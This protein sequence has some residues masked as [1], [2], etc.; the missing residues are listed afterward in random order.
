MG[1]QNIL[2]RIFE[3]R[4]EWKWKYDSGGGFCAWCMVENVKKHH[5]MVLYAFI[6][7]SLELT[8]SLS[9]I[10]RVYS[11]FMVGSEKL[12]FTLSYF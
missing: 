5:N 2:V 12:E 10:L 3:V 8:L 6:L 1:L 11:N 7:P 4:F 9:M